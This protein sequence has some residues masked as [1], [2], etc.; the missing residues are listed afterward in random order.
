MALHWVRASKYRELAGEKETDDAIDGRLRAG[1][2]IRDVH[3]RRPDGSKELWVN[4][5]AVND[6]AAGKPNAARHGLSS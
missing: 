6:W 2:W 4:L 5:N 1:I 3:A